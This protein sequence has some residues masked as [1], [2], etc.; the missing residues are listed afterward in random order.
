M[1]NLLPDTM[2]GLLNTPRPQ[3]KAHRDSQQAWM[4]LP[5]RLGGLGLQSAARARWAGWIGK[6][7][8]VTHYARDLKVQAPAEDTTATNPASLLGFTAALQQL[9]E[10]GDGNDTDAIQLADELAIGFL[11]GTRKMQHNVAQSW[12]TRST[13]SYSRT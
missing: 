10:A 11:P 1:D 5:T 4:L 12:P 13:R 6:T 8:H 2:S 9:R 3:D 7:V